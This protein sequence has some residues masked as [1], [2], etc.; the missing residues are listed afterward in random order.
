MTRRA[1]STPSTQASSTSASNR[2]VSHPAACSRA[3]AAA[4][5]APTDSAAGTLLQPPALLIVLERVGEFTQLAQQD[6]VEVVHAQV[7]A[8][9]VDPALAV[10]VGADLLGAVAGAHLSQPVGAQL[11]L[12]LGQGAL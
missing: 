9:V 4:R 8:V 7:D 1:R 3:V 2:G 10:V 11:G 12:L 6:L 5:A